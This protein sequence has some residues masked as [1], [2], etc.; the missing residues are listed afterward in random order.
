MMLLP[1]CCIEME[2]SQ[3][4]PEIIFLVVEFCS[5]QTQNGAFDEI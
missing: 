2:S 5:Q 1:V 4:E 3:L